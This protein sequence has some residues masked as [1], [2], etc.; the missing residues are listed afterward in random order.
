MFSYYF[1]F[2]LVI[3]IRSHLAFI[4]LR[5][6]TL[7]TLKC[8]VGPSGRW[9]RTIPSLIHNLR[10]DQRQRAHISVFDLFSE[11]SKCY[12]KN[13][14]KFTKFTIHN[15]KD[16]GHFSVLVDDDQVGEIPGDA[17]RNDPLQGQTSSVVHMGVWNNSGQLI[18][19]LH[20]PLQNTHQGASN[21][22]EWTINVLKV[23]LKSTN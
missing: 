10:I 18:T 15:K 4:S 22:S 3:K 12:F 9:Q 23:V 7:L 5:S 21:S 11:R 2:N 8:A 14:I 16:T 19:K 17:L 6:R 13:R 20:R 1:L